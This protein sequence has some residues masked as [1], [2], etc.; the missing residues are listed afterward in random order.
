MRRIRWKASAIVSI[1]GR[2]CG[3]RRPQCW[4]VGCRPTRVSLYCQL[5]HLVCICWYCKFGFVDSFPHCVVLPIPQWWCARDRW[6]SDGSLNYVVLKSSRFAA[7]MF[8]YRAP[9]LFR[10]LVIVVKCACEL[11]VGKTK[12]CKHASQTT[13]QPQTRVCLHSSADRSH[14]SKRTTRILARILV[15]RIESYD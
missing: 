4:S 15:C 14:V 9:N 13:R 3:W 8:F 7:V 6:A 1:I 11:M 5:R 10:A 12:E 2:R